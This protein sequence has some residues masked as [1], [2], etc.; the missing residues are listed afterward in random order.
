MVNWIFSNFEIVIKFFDVID[1][2]IDDMG[3][4]Y[5]FV[6]EFYIVVEELGCIRWIM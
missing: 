6:K 1:Y 4:F 3:V 5:V 2:C